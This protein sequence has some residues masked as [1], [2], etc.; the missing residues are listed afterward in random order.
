MKI[1][2]QYRSLFIFGAI[3]VV[4]LLVWIGSTVLPGTGDNEETS[5]TTGEALEPVYSVEMDEIKYLEV[6]NDQANFKLVP[7]EVTDKEGKVSFIWS[8]AGMEGYPFSS[9]TLESLANVAGHAYASKEIE[10]NAA[11][12]SLYGL[13]HPSAI[14]RVCLK[15][16]EIHEI[17]FG[18]EIPSGYYDYVTLDDTG[19]VCTVS[20]TTGDRVRASLLDLLDKNKIMDLDVNEL[21]KVEFIRAKDQLHLKADVKLVGEAGSGSEYLD[22][23]ITEPVR[24]TG[25]SDGLTKLV[26]EAASASVVSFVELNPKD[27]S[28][29]GL[30]EPAYT[31][32]LTTPKKTVQLSIGA[33][34]DG[35][36]YYAMTDQMPA[37]FT[38]ASSAFTSID[39]KVTEMMDRFVCL[40][41]IWEVSK[42]E[43]NILGTQ[44]VAEIEMTKDQRAD[45]E[46]VVFKLDG[47]N[48]RIFNESQKSLFSLFYQRIIGILIEGLD[49][50]AQ[51][52]NT[53]DAQLIFHIK[54]DEENQVPAYTKVVEFA[55]RDD[56]TY[57][58]FIDGV[59]GGY[60]VDGE[61]AFTSTRPDNEGVL[62]AYKMMRYA[63]E[64]AV[65]GV[66]NTQEG[67]VLD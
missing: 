64:H 31:F 52:V 48:A 40:E 59:Y 32:I 36:N 16:G 6:E 15:N 1:N 56:Y 66:F 30:E 39:M 11:D 33:A 38:V 53:K 60:Y 7:E 27:L 58:V 18:N 41:S 51:P 19:R 34:A 29:Y 14:L 9:S 26:N 61:K 35:S 2:K 45:D 5:A 12:L 67:Y 65:D 17:K 10:T 13:D 49:P 21:T 8:V 22:F 4:L 20:S 24:R 37:V 55:K 54:A 47:E 57:Y 3:I 43:A 25:S 28:V 44:F 63:M 62:T 23:T 42:I 50:D 46:G